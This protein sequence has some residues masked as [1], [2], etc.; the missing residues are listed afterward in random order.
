MKKKLRI[1]L[2][3]AKRLRSKDQVRMLLV[4]ATSVVL[5]SLLSNDPNVRRY[6]CCAGRITV[7]AREKDK[8]AATMPDFTGKLLPG[9]KNVLLNSDFHVIQDR[10]IATNAELS[11]REVKL[12][13]W[14][15]YF[16]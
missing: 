14:A 13:V 11:S 15:C 3:S 8:L 1:G 12:L 2:A 9:T 7:D 16:R 6:D 5:T 10:Q 4:R